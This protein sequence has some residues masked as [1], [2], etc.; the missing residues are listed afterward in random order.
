V[1]RERC[2]PTRREWALI[3]SARPV[4]RRFERTGA[5]RAVEKTAGVCKHLFVDASNTTP[6]LWT[7][8]HRCQ[9]GE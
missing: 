4:V 9:P 6:P 1:R 8:A 3:T 7:G 2:Q 5:K